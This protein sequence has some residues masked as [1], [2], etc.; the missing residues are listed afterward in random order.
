MPARQVWLFQFGCWAAI[1][2]AVVH[3]LVAIVPL[4]PTSDEALNLAFAASFAAIGS[5]GLA[6]SKRGQADALLMYAV[7][8]YCAI[9]SA[10]LLVLSLVY[11]FVVFI[12]PTLFIAAVTTCLA[13]AAVKAPGV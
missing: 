5:I 8:R 9:A 1:A 13:V 6:V 12:V 11:L 3:V 2:T 10:T 7:A 4:A